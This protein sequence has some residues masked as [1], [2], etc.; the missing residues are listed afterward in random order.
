MEQQPNAFI[1]HMEQPTEAEVTLVLGSTANLWN[2]L[3]D[4][5]S[6]ELGVTSQEWHRSSPKLGWALRLQV[7]KRRIIYLGPCS[8]CFR[9]ALIL[10]DRAVAAARKA[11][12]PA[13]LVRTIDEGARYPEG[14]AVRLLVKK[15]SD[16]AGIR[17]L[18]AVKL[19]N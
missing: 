14:T 19:A 6:T 3:V 17:E 9:V 7:K 5:L 15:S 1:G 16:L 12:L 10:G 11:G 4:S 18:A 8:G 2:K 13:S